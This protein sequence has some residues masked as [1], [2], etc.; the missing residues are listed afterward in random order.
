MRNCR[1]K[2]AIRTL[3]TRPQLPLWAAKHQI[4]NWFAVCQ[5]K[6]RPSNLVAGCEVHQTLARLCTEFQSVAPTNHCCI[7]ELD[8]VP[9]H[10]C[11]LSIGVTCSTHR[12]HT[13]PYKILIGEPR[14]ELQLQSRHKYRTEVPKFFIGLF[15]KVFGIQ[16]LKQMQL[17][18]S[19]MAINSWQAVNNQFSG[20][21]Q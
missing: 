9:Q 13:N 6:Q 16:I 7:K 19:S 3:V 15:F 10:G 17:F 8:R 12:W 1:W 21:V 14:G 5:A 11:A 18:L 2:T 4:N 20:W